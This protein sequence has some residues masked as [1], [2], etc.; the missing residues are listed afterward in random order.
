MLGTRSHLIARRQPLL[1]CEPRFEASVAETQLTALV[2]SPGP[3]ATVALE[4]EVAAIAASRLSPVT[5]VVKTRR[6]G[7]GKPV[8]SLTER[9]AARRRFPQ[10]E[11]AVS[12]ARC[13][14]RTVSIY[15]HKP[16]ARQEEC[17]LE[18]QPFFLGSSWW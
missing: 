3:Q 8:R 15:G 11:A 1:V 10:P 6:D 16:F 2:L 18:M 4:P 7:K 13:V 17:W 12:G 5:V 14:A 9:P